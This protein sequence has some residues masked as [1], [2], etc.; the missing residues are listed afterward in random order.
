MKFV[1]EG[2]E[3]ERLKFRLLEPGDFNDWLKLF[4]S[5]DVARFIG[6]DHLKTA[7]EQCRL[8]FDIQERR[9]KNDLGG[10]NVLIEKD[11][12]QMAGQC[13]LLIQEVDGKE[14]MEIG[15]SVLPRFRGRGFATEAAIKCR[16]F[17]FENSFTSELISIIHIENKKSEKVAVKNGMK[18]NIQTIHKKMPVH[19]F[20]ILKKDWQHLFY[21]NSNL[22]T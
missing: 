10:M 17:A 13:G 12:G 15:Y 20:R 8:W 9:Y 16:D 4:E 14:K 19:I 6:F 22:S 2:E 7:E 1:L 11:T 5:P 21:S 18:K 3:S